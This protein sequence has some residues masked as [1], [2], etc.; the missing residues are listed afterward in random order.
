MSRE[1][2]WYNNDSEKLYIFVIP[3]GG[4]LSDADDEWVRIGTL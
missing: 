3:R 1:E 4:S 2:I